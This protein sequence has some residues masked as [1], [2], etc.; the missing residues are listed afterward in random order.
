MKIHITYRDSVQ[1]GPDDWDVF[2]KVIDCQE[3]ETLKELHQKLTANWPNK[4]FDGEIHFEN[5][6]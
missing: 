5:E 6:S 1:R 4:S 3:T 2:T